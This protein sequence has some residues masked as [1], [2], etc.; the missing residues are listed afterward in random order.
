MLNVLDITPKSVT[1]VVTCASLLHVVTALQCLSR[2]PF[3]LL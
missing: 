3:V 2:I 1:V